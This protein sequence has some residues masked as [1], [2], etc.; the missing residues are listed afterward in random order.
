MKLIK[1]SGPFCLV[2]SAA[3]ILDTT[4][5]ELHKEIGH[6]GTEFWWEGKMRGIHI[7]EIIMC[8]RRR[9]KSLTPIEMFPTV[10]YLSDGCDPKMIFNVPH[11]EVRFYMMIRDHRGILVGE[12]DSGN[13]HACAWDGMKVFDPRGWIYDLSDFNIRECWLLI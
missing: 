2:A 13:P 9:N 7:Q 5:E 12:T 8:V 3:M 10:S 4:I 1:Q 6:D 11:A